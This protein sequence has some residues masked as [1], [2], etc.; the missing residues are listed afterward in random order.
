M[1]EE[2]VKENEG[3]DEESMEEILHSIRDIIASDEGTEAEAAA[4][5]VPEPEAEPVKAEEE[6]TPEK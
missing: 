3:Q 4:E 1:S 6:A 2:A 5:S